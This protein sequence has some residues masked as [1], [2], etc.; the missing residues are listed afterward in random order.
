MSILESR[1]ARDFEE[2][3]GHFLHLINRAP[4]LCKGVFDEQAYVGA[5]GCNCRRVVDISASRCSGGSTPTA[6]RA[7]FAPDSGSR[8]AGSR[9]AVRDTGL[10]LR[11]EPSS[12]LHELWP[13]ELVM[14]DWVLGHVTRHC[15]NPPA[16]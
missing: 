13:F 10:Y 1:V 8:E 6:H 16:D 11:P 15:S 2:A 14:S 4:F 9:L 12:G 3:G 7:G 5:N